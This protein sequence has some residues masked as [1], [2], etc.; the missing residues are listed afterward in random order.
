ML[1]HVLACVGAGKCMFTYMLVFISKCV[2]VYVCLYIYMYI[3][4]LEEKNECSRK[5]CSLWLFFF[6]KLEICGYF[7]DLLPAAY[8]HYNTWNLG[9]GDWNIYNLGTLNEFF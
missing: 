6:L 9:S 4:S 5:G 1:L 2:C 7:T 3:F 8:R